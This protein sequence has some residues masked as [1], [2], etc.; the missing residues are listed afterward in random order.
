MRSLGL[1]LV[2]ACSACSSLEAAQEC[3]E[4]TMPI[5]VGGQ[6]Q[7]S[8]VLACLQADDSWRITQT[9]PG[10]PT[11]VCTVPPY[12]SDPQTLQ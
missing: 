10:L 1:L 5:T 9:T 12:D 6:Q 3:R 7:Q 2:L 4:Y 8:D 11:Q